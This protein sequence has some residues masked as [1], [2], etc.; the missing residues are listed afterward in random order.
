MTIKQRKEN[1]AIEAADFAGRE[2]F[3]ASR[4]VA[5]MRQDCQTPLYCVVW[6]ATNGKPTG[7]AWTSRRRAEQVR[8]R[9]IADGSFVRTVTHYC[10]GFAF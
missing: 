7:N 1:A 8:D 2:D 9:K 10:S 3:P 4:L 6:M 5:P